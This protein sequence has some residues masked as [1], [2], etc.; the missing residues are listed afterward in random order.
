[1]VWI[2]DMTP[3]YRKLIVKCYI[4]F[5]FITDGPLQFKLP[6]ILTWDWTINI[7]NTVAVSSAWGSSF[8]TDS[9]ELKHHYHYNFRCRYIHPK[10]TIKLHL[11]IR[12]KFWQLDF[13]NIRHKHHG[14]VAKQKTYWWSV[15]LTEQPNTLLT[16]SSISL[17]PRSSLSSLDSWDKDSGRD[18]NRFSRSSRDCRQVRLQHTTDSDHHNLKDWLI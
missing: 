13:S 9:A 11:C 2:W 12:V 1:M 3:N 18:F 8:W 15:W 4:N 16:N 10:V 6:Q 17:S 14:F 5:P 7:L